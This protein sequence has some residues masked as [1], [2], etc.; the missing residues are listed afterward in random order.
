[1][2]RTVFSCNRKSNCFRIKPLRRNTI[3]HQLSILNR[4]IPFQRLRRFER[5]K[6]SVCNFANNRGNSIH[7][8]G[9]GEKEN[10][11]IRFEEGKKRRRKCLVSSLRL[12]ACKGVWAAIVI[13]Q[14]RRSN[15]N[16][17]NEWLNYC[18]VPGLIDDSSPK[19]PVVREFQHRHD[20]SIYSLLA[21]KYHFD[22]DPA[23][24]FWESFGRPVMR[25]RPKG[26]VRYKS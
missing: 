4:Q 26:Y 24:A 2:I 3:F 10:F 23:K 17:F 6:H 22:I 11:V 7:R 1:M 20:Q 16:F 8:R 15:E 9:T 14:K 18:T 19:V 25:N 21:W 12:P 5:R 13:V